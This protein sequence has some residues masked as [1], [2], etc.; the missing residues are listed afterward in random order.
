MAEKKVEKIIS[1]KVKTKKKNE[2]QKMAGTL[3]AEDAK[4]VK[5]Y[6]LMDVLVPAVKD[7]I[8][9]IVTNGIRMLLRGDTKARSGGSSN[10]SR[11]LVNCYQ[12]FEKYI[13]DFS[14]WLTNI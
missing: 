5:S 7:A 11:I 9:D 12:N 4:S 3:I 8:E 13:N 10:I 6:I 2:L 14:N 1:G